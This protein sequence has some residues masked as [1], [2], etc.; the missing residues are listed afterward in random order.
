MAGAVRCIPSRGASPAL[1][2]ACGSGGGPKL[3]SGAR[4]APSSLWPASGP[5]DSATVA[6][7]SSAIVTEVGLAG[8]Q[9]AA[10]TARVPASGTGR[11][12]PGLAT[13]APR[14]S[15]TAPSGRWAT[16]R[17][18]EPGAA[19]DEQSPRGSSS[20]QVVSSI[21]RALGHAKGG[22]LRVYRPG[23]FGHIVEG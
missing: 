7:A 18:S 9:V 10:P 16:I 4:A 22:P 5:A 14:G 3:G 8:P 1:V 20:E 12:R 13:V 21:A 15:G 6:G 17:R 23:F 11:S 2:T 19:G